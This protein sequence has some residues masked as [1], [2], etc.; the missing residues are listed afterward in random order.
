M[1]AAYM[2]KITLNFSG[3]GR[4][5]RGLLDFTGQSPASAKTKSLLLWLLVVLALDFVPTSF[6]FK[7]DKEKKQKKTLADLK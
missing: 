3:F 2:A 5:L 6:L 1:P 4:A 7:A